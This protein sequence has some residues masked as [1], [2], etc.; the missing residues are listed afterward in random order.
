MPTYAY[1]ATSQQPTSVSHAI[2]G[3]FTSPSEPALI[4]AKC[5]RLEM[6]ALTPEGLRRVFDVPVNGRIS[7]MQVVRLQVSWLARGA[8]ALDFWGVRSCLAYR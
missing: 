8:A 6:H 7:S 4:V 2:V 3:N 1:V 5:S